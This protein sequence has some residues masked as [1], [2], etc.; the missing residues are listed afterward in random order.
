MKTKLCDIDRVYNEYVSQCI[1]CGDD[2]LRFEVYAHLH[3]G[4][5]LIEA[6]NWYLNQ[7]EVDIPENY[8]GTH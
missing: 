2:A 7:F 1:A 4:I 8:G 5:D 3:Y 6:R